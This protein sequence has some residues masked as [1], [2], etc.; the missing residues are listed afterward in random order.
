[1][2]HQNRPFPWNLSYKRDEYTYIRDK[3]SL[4]M[5][6]NS[7]QTHIRDKIAK[8]SKFIYSRLD[9]MKIMG[10]AQLVGTGLP[11]GDLRFNAWARVLEG[12]CLQHVR[13]RTSTS[14]RPIFAQLLSDVLV[15]G[16]VDQALRKAGC[17]SNLHTSLH[18][19]SPNG[20]I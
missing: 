18:A 1:M 4:Y 6:S 20:S 17:C 3:I 13:A 15:G 10:A 19:T 16:W 9:G 8:N 2:I 11:M 7:L 12:Q 5:Y 14:R